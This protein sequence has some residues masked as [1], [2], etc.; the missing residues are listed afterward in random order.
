MRRLLLLICVC[1]PW[2]AWAAPPS[3]LIVAG[4]ASEPA[5][6]R[7]LLEL[8]RAAGLQVDSVSTAGQDPA[9]LGARMLGYDAVL[10][11]YV[12]LGALMP[13]INS[14]RGVLAQHRGVVFPGLMWRDP[15]LVR[16]LSPEQARTLFAY[17][18]NGGR[19]NYRRMYAWMRQTLFKLGGAAAPPIV[20]PE[21]GYYHPDYPQRVFASL[22]QLL[23]W[24]ALP[25]ARPV[26]G[27]GIHRSQLAA[28]T[29][30]SADALIRGLEAKGVYAFGYYHPTDQPMAAM[31]RRDGQV[32]PDLLISFRG[33]MSSPELR[34]A[35][36]A[37]LD[38]PMLN[39]LDV[40]MDS[41]DQ[42]QADDQGFPMFAMGPWFVQAEMAGMIDP[43]VVSTRSADDGHALVPGHLEALIQRSLNYLKLRRTPNADKRLAMLV[44]N[45]PEGEEN[46][47]ASFLNLPESIGAIAAALQQ[48]GYRIDARDGAQIVAALQQMMR[49]YYRVHDET[50]MRE[51]LA[52]DLAEAVPVAEYRAWFATLPEQ[53]R[54]ETLAAWGDPAQ[55]YLNLDLDGQRVF[56]IPRLKLGN[57]L[58]LP[59]PLRGDKRDREKDILHDKRVPVH[60]AYRAVYHYLVHHYRADAIIHLG[61]HG[62]QEWLSGKELGTWKYDDTQTTIG[63]VPVVYPYN[64]QN[65]G[66]AQI[67]KRRGRAVVISHNTPP[68]APAGLYDELAVLHELTHNYRLLEDGRVR[69]NTAGEIL[70]QL[71]ALKLDQ[72]LA[73][74]IAGQRAALLADFQPV[75]ERVHDYLEQIAG[76]AQP[77]G[78]HTY[79][80]VA[81]TDHV[82]LTILQILG[83]DYIAAAETVDQRKGRHDGFFTRPY[84]EILD[85]ASFQLLKRALTGD[86]PLETFPPATREWLAEGRRHFANFLGER[87]MESLLAA[88][89]ARYIPTGTGNDPLRNP[90]AVPTGRNVYAFDPDKI[91]TKAA[92]AAG[93]ALAQDLIDRYKA[94]HGVYPDKLAFSLWSTETLKHYGVLEAEVLYLLGVRPVWN[95]RDEVVDVEVIPMHELKRPRVDVVLSATG[96]YRDNLAPVMDRL[97]RAV[98]KIAALAEPDNPLHANA[99]AL[100]QRLI[101]QGVEPEQAAR[102][103]RVRMFANQSGVYGTQLPDATLASDTWEDETPLAQTYLSRMGYLYGAEDGTRN[104]K[105]DGIDLYAENLRGTKAAVFSRSS[106]LH[107]ILSID[108]PF[109]YLGGI[110]LAV[111]HLDGTTPEMYIS[112]LRNTRDFRNDSVAEFI[113]KELRTRYYHPRWVAEMMAEGYSGA[114]EILDVVNNFWGWNVMDRNSVRPD[115]WQELY[116]IYV[117]D[118]LELGVDDWF[119]QVHPAARAQIAERM[120]EAVRKGYWDAPEAVVKRLTEVWLEIA[121]SRDLYTENQVFKDYVAATAAGFGLDARAAQPQPPAAPPAATPSQAPTRSV[122][123]LKLERASEPPARPQPLRWWL[124]LL[125]LGVFLSGAL[126]EQSRWRLAQA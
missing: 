87:E 54:S 40:R 75:F 117:E 52:R 6:L 124:G 116:A 14:Y 76:M 20:Y 97:S 39:A 45:S 51:L 114:T 48:A 37:A 27:V 72:D 63:D 23:A 13:V 69:Q 93:Q 112:D 94:K 57:L 5:K 123:G 90:D 99:E 64:V 58:L 53:L 81:Q 101:G 119:K 115:Q 113:N 28:D 107:G 38:M 59:Q 120:L 7:M 9:Q 100:R 103:S 79:G 22:E 10:L 16:G 26:I 102:L 19:E 121:A 110:G 34:G 8:G 11:D 95:R 66:E 33:I 111:R 36:L 29:T 126:Y 67:A 55:T 15:G 78:M 89:E 41:L 46:F 4:S 88:L 77:L 60:H 1:L 92:W 62:T 3:V 56:V 85:T 12:Y 108:H 74:D 96:L 24:R 42:W 65:V 82:L 104:L 125:L 86:A 25:G 43:T 118:K 68:F 44:W 70:D 122:E 61:T 2:S 71:V 31:M 47:S 18:D 80:A 73:L 35:D 84:A 106:N 98:L 105:L 30:A 21:A 17:Y 91:P 83:P 49:P 109:E 50:A 32:F